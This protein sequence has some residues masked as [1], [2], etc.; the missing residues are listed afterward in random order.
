MSAIATMAVMAL[1]NVLRVLFAQA[2]FEQIFAKIIIWGLRKLAAMT[3][4]K[5]DDELAEPLIA[6]L[7]A[8]MGWKPSKKPDEPAQP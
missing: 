2:V 3:Q 7:E 4:T 6:R 8:H 5:I 1:L